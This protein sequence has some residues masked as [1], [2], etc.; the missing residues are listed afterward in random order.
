MS[1]YFFYQFFFIQLL[2]PSQN[3]T[4]PQLKQFTFFKN[5]KGKATQVQD[6]PSFIPLF[7]TMFYIFN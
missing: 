1:T 4:L 6:L 5:Y 7:L 3:Y 2:F